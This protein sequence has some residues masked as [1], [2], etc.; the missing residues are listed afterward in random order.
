M[1]LLFIPTTSS[2][3]QRTEKT[4]ITTNQIGN[5]RRTMKLNV[6][7]CYLSQ[8]ENEDK[9]NITLNNELLPYQSTQRDH[10]IFT[11][12]KVVT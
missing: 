1:N 2:V 4:R 10:Y 8:I 9:P 12:N 5:L 3:L 11:R 6:N 7:Q